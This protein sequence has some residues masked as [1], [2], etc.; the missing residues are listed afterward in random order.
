MLRPG[1]LRSLPRL[2]RGSFQPLSAAGRARDGPTGWLRR[3][4]RASRE[5]SDSIARSISSQVGAIASDAIATPIARAVDGRRI[6]GGR[7]RRGDRRRRARPAC[8]PAGAAGGRRVRRRRRSLRA[9]AGGGAG[10]RSGCGAGPAAEDEPVRRSDVWPGEPPSRS[11]ASADPRPWSWARGALTRRPAGRRRRRK[12][13]AQ[14]AAAGALHRHRAERAGIVR[15]DP[16][17]DRDGPRPD[18]A[19]PP[20]RIRVRAARSPPRCCGSVFSEPGGPARTV[21]LP[22]GQEQSR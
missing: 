4:D 22:H 2:S 17:R 9:G 3:A 16:G 1:D 11:S 14:A 21:I 20:R 12:R 5:L 7:D 8:H 10:C 13:P 6:A 19:R 15:V 18:R